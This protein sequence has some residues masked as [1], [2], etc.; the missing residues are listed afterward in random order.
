MVI[1]ITLISALVIWYM[2][3]T[4]TEQI[5]DST[6]KAITYSEFLQMLDEG[7]VESVLV[8]N[9]NTTVIAQDET[10]SVIYGMPK[11]VVDSNLQDAIM[12]LDEIID[13]LNKLW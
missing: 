11:A 2:F 5:K 12:S 7:K 8:K 6:N 1:I 3:W 4:L 13:F 10:T 9:D